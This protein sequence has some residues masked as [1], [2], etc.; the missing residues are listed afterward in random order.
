MSGWHLQRLVLGDD[1]IPTP[2]GI[3]TLLDAVTVTVQV[4]DT[5]GE[6]TAHLTLSRAC[7]QRLRDALDELLEQDAEEAAW[8]A[9]HCCDARIL[10]ATYRHAG[11][12]A[13]AV[14]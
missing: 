14:A 8:D 11:G 10:P 5:S 13:W 7:A 4:R 1:D 12:C 9:E 6:E 2:G 3:Q